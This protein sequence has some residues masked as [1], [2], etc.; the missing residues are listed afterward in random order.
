MLGI[1]FSILAGLLMSIQGVFNTRC[2]EKIGLWETN[3]VVQITGFIFTLIILLIVGNG[4]FKKITQ[5]NKLYLLGGIIG[6][7]IIYFVMRGISDLGPTYSIS[8]ILVAQLI[9]AAF[10]DFFGLFGAEKISFHFT[11]IIGVI[12]MISGIIVFKL[13]G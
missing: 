11:K 5:V 6:V 12:L 3:I 8:T 7:L 1:V 10:I 9:T 2:S 4:D 13:K